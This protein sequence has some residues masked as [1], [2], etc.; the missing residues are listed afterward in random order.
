MKVIRIVVKVVLITSLMLFGL[1]SITYI[2]IN[3]AYKY[4]APDFEITPLQNASGH[5]ECNEYGIWELYLEGS[6]YDRGVLY[7]ELTSDL[8]KM[9]EE[10]FLTQLNGLVPNQFSQK[11]ITTLITF[12]NRGLIDNIPNEFTEEIYGVSR[13]FSDE[14]NFV[15]PQFMRIIN[16]HAAHDLG[17]AL[18]D[19]SVVGCTSFGVLDTTD[20]IN[21]LSIGR[22]FDFYV[23][24]EF[25]EEKIITFMRPDDGY[26]FASYSWAGFMGVVSGMNEAG[27]SVT[28]NAAK[29]NPP[30]SAKSPISILTREILQYCSTI[31]EAIVIA[32]KRDVFVSESIMVGSKEDGTIA[33]IEKSP[34]GMGVY[35][36][37]G[38]RIICAN[39]YQSETFAADPM[40]LTN[41]EQS[42]SAS[43]YTRVEELVPSDG[44]FSIDQIADVLRDQND[45]CGDTLGM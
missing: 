37:D 10:V 27:L 35:N 22:N 2:F 13:S 20:S 45:V 39:H 42:E 12:F 1:I 40:N 4:D 7:G 31:E 36:M 17:H 25:A 38:N 15:L 14:F 44:L 24:D 23:G 11:F 26:A 9:Q 19:Y 21:S 29:S 43:R 6:P 34:E 41:I 8:M 28:I 16:Y 3:T 33:I 32:E 18:N 5:I 30:L